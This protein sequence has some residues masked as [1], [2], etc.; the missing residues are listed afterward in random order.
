MKSNGFY[1]LE[2]DV[3]RSIYIKEEPELASVGHFHEGMEIVALL[4]GSVEAFHTG[5]SRIMKPNEIFF[6]DSFEVHHYR[7][8]TPEIKAIVIVLSSEYTR[9]FREFYVGKTIP[10]HLTDIQKNVEII[11]VMKAW[12]NEKEKSYMLN[13]GYSNILFSKF[14]ENYNLEKRERRRDKGVSVK[15]LRYVNDKYCENISLAKAAK[16]IGYT[17]EYCSK[18]FSEVVGMSFRNY[19]NFLRL[20]KAKE[21]FS[22]KSELKL[23]TTEIIYKCGF[24]STAT[25]YRVLKTFQNK[26]MKF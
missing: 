24:S 23:T 18:V 1:L 25:F 3:A 4:E 9:V 21:Y 12:L 6:A 13:L 10:V 20:E 11:R 14:V 5:Q 26:N 22:M 19:L 8:I 15:L 17:Q 7:K 16:E 2:A